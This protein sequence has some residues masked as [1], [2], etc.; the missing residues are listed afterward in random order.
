MILKEEKF[1]QQKVKEGEEEK[2]KLTF[3]CDWFCYIDF[4]IKKTD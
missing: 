3:Q 1:Q 2:R 4:R